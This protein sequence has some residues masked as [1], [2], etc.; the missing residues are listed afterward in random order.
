MPNEFWFSLLL[1]TITGFPQLLKNHWNSD[2]FQDHGKI[3]ELHEKFLKF[4][5]MRK[6][7]KNHW[8]LD[9]LLM[10]KSLNSEIDIVLT[11][12]MCKEICILHIHY[13]L[14][15]YSSNQ[16]GTLYRFS[17]KHPI[18]VIR[19][20]RRPCVTCGHMFFHFVT[21]RIIMEIWDFCL[22]IS[23]K[24]YWNF[25]RLV[26]GNPVSSSKPLAEPVLDDHR[27]RL[28]VNSLRL[29]VACMRWQTRPWMV[30]IMPCHLFSAKPLS[31]PMLV[32]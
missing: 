23:L 22:E 31:E 10:E 14:I 29:S 17:W 9:Q 19:C 24:N 18:V 7:W 12:Y 3:I 11:N 20:V 16:V 26:C 2:P 28:C 6:S 25:S 4:V 27:G 5:K 15:Y 21:F 1:G 8:I 32:Y 13:L 30:Q